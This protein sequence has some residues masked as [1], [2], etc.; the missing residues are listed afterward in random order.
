MYSSGFLLSFSAVIGAGIVVPVLERNRKGRNWKNKKQEMGRRKNGNL[1]RIKLKCAKIR[2]LKSRD[3][4]KKLAMIFEKICQMLIASIGVQL[5][6]LPVSFYFFGEVSLAGI[7]LNLIVLPTVGIVL[8]S[9]VMGLLLG[10]V[11]LE[12][13]RI[14]ILPGRILA[15]IYEKLCE[16]SGNLPFA[17]WIAGQPR[18]W[19]IIVYYLLL[20]SAG[21]LY[22]YGV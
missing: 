9:G 10:C 5:V 11:N 12:I 13:A 15:E 16:M 4:T 8:G 6:M 21:I 19:Q 2:R 22:I 18:V 17:T 14:F 1:E 7:F 3:G 20:G